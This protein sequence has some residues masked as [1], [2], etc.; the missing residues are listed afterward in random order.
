M[1]DLVLERTLPVSAERAFAFVTRPDSMMSWR[2]P[3]GMSLPDARLDFTRTG[4][5]HSVMMCAEGR[6]DRAERR[7]QPGLGLLAR[8]REGPGRRSG[9]GPELPDGPRRFGP[10]R[11]R[12][13]SR[14]VTRCVRAG[15]PA[16]CAPGRYFCRSVQI[17]V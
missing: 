4:P 10:G 11:G 1:S 2:G 6:R 9:N 17:A 5:W 14:D 15:R 3:E 7:R 13:G 12:R 8:H 16:R